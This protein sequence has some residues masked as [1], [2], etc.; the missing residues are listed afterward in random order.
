MQ[1]TWELTGDSLPVNKMSNFH[2]MRAEVTIKLERTR[3]QL[4]LT[5]PNVNRKQACKCCAYPGLLPV[6]VLVVC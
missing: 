1:D 6:E 3:V 5:L 2:V 4:V